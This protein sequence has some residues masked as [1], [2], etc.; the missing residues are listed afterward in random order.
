MTS[1]ASLLLLQ[2]SLFIQL[3]CC[4]AV[5]HDYCDKETCISCVYCAPF[6]GMMFMFPCIMPLLCYVVFSLS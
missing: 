2:S 3:R 6:A 5:L 1:V 4:N